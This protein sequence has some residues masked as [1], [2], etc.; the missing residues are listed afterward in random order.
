M[1]DVK[2]SKLIHW[3]ILDKIMGISKLRQ[4][5]KYQPISDYAFDIIFRK[6]SS[7][8]FLSV[9]RA[10]EN[11]LIPNNRPTKGWVDRKSKYP[12]KI[13][14]MLIKIDRKNFKQ[15]C[16]LCLGLDCLYILI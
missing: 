8:K 11:S 10:H 16:L 2:M 9:T 13:T 6:L 5:Q 15:I 1:V 12:E 7:R 4:I 14:K 3:V